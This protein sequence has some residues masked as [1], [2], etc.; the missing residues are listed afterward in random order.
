[1]PSSKVVLLGDLGGEVSYQLSL[2]GSSY[3]FSKVVS[4]PRRITYGGDS[5]VFDD[6][7]DGD[8]VHFRIGDNGM[9]ILL[10]VPRAGAS[11]C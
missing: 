10:M 7:V 1:M 4:K 9:R 11:L 5:F 3:D 2:L 8:A 6:T